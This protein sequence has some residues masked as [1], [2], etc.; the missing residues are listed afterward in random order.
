MRKPDR[1]QLFEIRPPVLAQACER[2]RCRSHPPLDLC[3]GNKGIRVRY[4]L[5]GLDDMAPF[6]GHVL[7]VPENPKCCHDSSGDEQ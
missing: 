6:G 2:M 3:K 4:S 7:P 5:R 1:D